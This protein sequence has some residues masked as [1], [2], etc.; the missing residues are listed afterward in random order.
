MKLLIVV[1]ALLIQW[2]CLNIDLYLLPAEII[3]DSIT[4]EKEKEDD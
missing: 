1:A 3:Y 2:G 4:E